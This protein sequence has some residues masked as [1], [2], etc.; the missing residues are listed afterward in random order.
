M[1]SIFFT[2]R[3]PIR[4][5]LAIFYAAGIV[6]LS[7]LPPHDLPRVELFPGADKVVHF[8]MY[9]IFSMLGCWSSKKES[10]RSHF[11]LIFPITIVWGV[12]MEIFQFSMHLGRNFSWL[13]VLANSFGAAVGII[14]YN[15]ILIGFLKKSDV[16]I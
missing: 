10:I 13:D 16:S 1:I 12:I 3:Q 7:L 14:I 9:F 4:I 6:A 5:I 11:Y 2:V 15:L 8:L